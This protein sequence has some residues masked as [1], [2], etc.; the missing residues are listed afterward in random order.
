M[1]NREWLASNS[2][3]RIAPRHSF[4]KLVPGWGKCINLICDY[5]DR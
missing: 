3:V 1:T 4:F 2:S 5:V